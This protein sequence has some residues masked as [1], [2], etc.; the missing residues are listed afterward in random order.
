MSNPVNLHLSQLDIS[1]NYG[2]GN[3]VATISADDPDHVGIASYS[4]I[5]D[6]NGAF[7][8]IGD[9]LYVAD[10]SRLDYEAIA[11]GTL[12]ITV[13]V[14]DLDQETTDAHFTIAIDDLDEAPVFT[15]GGGATTW[16]L[17]ATEGALVAVEPIRVTMVNGTLQFTADPFQIEKSVAVAAPMASDPE[18]GPLQYR[19]SGGN[20]AAWFSFGPD[21]WMTSTDDPQPLLYFHSTIVGSFPDF[22]HP[23]D[24]DKDNVYEV[25]ITASDGVYEA[26][27]AIRLT[28]TNDSSKGPV[29]THSLGFP[30]FALAA[31]M[32][33]TT[34]VTTITATPDHAGDPVTYSLG[35]NAG[36]SIDPT[37]GALSFNV[38]PDYE[39]ISRDSFLVVAVTATAGGHSTS[40]AVYVVVMNA[41][42]APTDIA[43][44]AHA[45]RESAANGTVVGTLAGVD[46][47]SHETCTYALLDDAGGR[48]ALG[49]A[50]QRRGRRRQRTGARL[51][52]ARQPPDHCR[53]DQFAW[54]DLH[55]G[56]DGGRQQCRSGSDHRNQ[57]G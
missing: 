29:F 42:D 37:T 56:V 39:A 52:A 12:G 13:R 20:D 22:E 57:R 36:F 46:Q 34:A 32:E 53:S 7:E 10:S 19:I 31:V 55:Q 15:S 38:A 5:D 27:Q 8:I 40:E 48:F 54:S 50:E 9:G 35:D 51:R 49:G 17:D 47:D 3:L 45:V 30:Y 1:E 41:N 44:A 18:G 6:A 21:A 26:A 11:S 43:L 2:T 33:N 28:I 4:L 14:T 24:G 25:T 16:D 23:A